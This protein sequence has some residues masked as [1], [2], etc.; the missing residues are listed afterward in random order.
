MAYT[1]NYNFCALLKSFKN[2][3]LVHF[4]TTRYLITRYSW[5]IVM[6]SLLKLKL[7][8]FETALKL[9]FVT[10]LGFRRKMRENK[11]ARKC[12][13]ILVSCIRHHMINLHRKPF[14]LNF[15]TPRDISLKQNSNNPDISMS[16]SLNLINEVHFAIKFLLHIYLRF[17]LH[18][19]WIISK[20]Y[21]K[22]LFGTHSSELRF[23]S[24]IYA[25][26]DML[27]N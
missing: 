3:I 21:I 26:Y 6:T 19:L 17:M 7:K 10:W 1:W 9:Y 24:T 13:K 18:K 20:V 27:Y 16:F 8:R 22:Q 25:A 14:G 12:T 4:W 23:I 11:M 2:K 5:L 15:W